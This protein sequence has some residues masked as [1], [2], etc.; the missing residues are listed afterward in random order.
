MKKA[1][2]IDRDGTLIYEPDDFQVD[3]FE[4][5]R[6]IPGVFSSLGRIANELDYELVMVSNQDG[7]GSDKF[8]TEQF[9]SLHNFILQTFESQSTRFAQG[10]IDCAL[11]TG[12][13]WNS[14]L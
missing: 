7:L 4:K 13:Q 3:S 12:L 8:P 9:A 14:T 1:L 10:C 11:A 5:L 6:F 2:F